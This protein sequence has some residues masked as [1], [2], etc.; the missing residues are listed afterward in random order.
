VTAPEFTSLLYGGVAACRMRTIAVGFAMVPNDI[1]I[2][3]PSSP[4]HTACCRAIIATN[5]GWDV[6]VEI[7]E[8]VVSVTHC[9]D[10]HRVERLCE[11]IKREWLRDYPS[12]LT[13]A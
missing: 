3:L 11:R 12:P 1:V 9:T 10:W 6:A 8:R 7:D 4:D 13:R 5:S 2:P